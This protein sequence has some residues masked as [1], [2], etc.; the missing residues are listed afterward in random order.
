MHVLSQKKNPTALNREN[1]TT[2]WKEKPPAFKKPNCHHK[3]KPK[4]ILKASNYVTSGYVTDRLLFVAYD[5]MCSTIQIVKLQTLKGDTN[6]I[7][8]ACIDLYT[9]GK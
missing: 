8:K 4:Y 6:T 1:P 2:L 9:Y 7:M 3:E 5:R